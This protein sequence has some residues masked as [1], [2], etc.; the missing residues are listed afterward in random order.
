MNHVNHAAIF[1]STKKALELV[2]CALIC[3]GHTVTCDKYG[4]IN[5]VD[6]CWVKCSVCYTSTGKPQIK[7]VPYGKF[8]AIHCRPTKGIWPIEA[9]CSKILKLV[10]MVRAEYGEEEPSPKIH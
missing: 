7:L 1:A 6:G 3:T 9:M 5:W 8:P 2:T 4:S 10:E